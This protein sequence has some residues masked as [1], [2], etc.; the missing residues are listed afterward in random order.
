MRGGCSW[1]SQEIKMP[2]VQ[3]PSIPFVVPIRMVVKIT[4]DQ[5][6][7]EYKNLEDKVIEL[8]EQ[9]KQ[10]KKTINDLESKINELDMKL[11]QIHNGLQN[12]ISSNNI[13]M[14]NGFEQINSY[15][16]IIS[17]KVKMLENKDKFG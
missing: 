7:G 3:I 9:N 13:V 8:E 16:N 11:S 2:W 5:M 10:L 17:H 1:L 6:M 4:D 12:K 14:N 15:F